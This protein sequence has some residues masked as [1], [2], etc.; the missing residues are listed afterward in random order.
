MPVPAAIVTTVKIKK[1]N[2]GR[3]GYEAKASIP[4]IADSSGSVK[5]FAS[6]STGNT[7]SKARR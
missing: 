7:P 5:S 1:I 4:K 6:R 2:R 3:Y